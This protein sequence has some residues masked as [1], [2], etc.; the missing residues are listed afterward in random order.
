MTTST[1]NPAQQPSE[2][3]SQTAHPSPKVQRQIANPAEIVLTSQQQ[4]RYQRLRLRVQRALRQSRSKNRLLNQYG[5]RAAEFIT[6]VPDVF[7]LMCKLTLDKRVPIKEKAKLGF[8]IAYF[9]SPIDLIPATLTGPIG[10]VDD[11]ALAAY[12]LN[13]LL[14]QVDV[15]IVRE[16]WA[17]KDDILTI[18]Q[19]ISQWADKFFSTNVFD[20]LRH[21]IDNKPE[22]PRQQMPSVHQPLITNE[23]PCNPN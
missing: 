14:N 16:H 1:R 5:G 9:V 6:L 11:L 19:D 12:V 15:D 18:L 13:S 17:G 22:L 2:S 8:A 3:K 20:K 7:H 23:K 21:W 10:F 4:D